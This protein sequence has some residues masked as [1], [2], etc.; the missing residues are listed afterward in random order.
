MAASQVPAW[1]RVCGLPA[2]WQG[3]PRW[4]VLET[5]FA[6]GNRFLA[7]WQRWAQ[8]PA[9]PRILHVVAL[10]GH[11][12]ERASL[13]QALGEHPDL[14]P[15]AGQVLGQWFGFLPGFHRLV[16]HGGRLQLT[17]EKKRKQKRMMGE[18][19]GK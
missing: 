5:D 6:D 14:A 4:C 16:L 19:V 10:A 17:S 2:A 9:A 1:M 12:P 13:Q 11:A 15:W 18:T 3:L 8:D 7:L